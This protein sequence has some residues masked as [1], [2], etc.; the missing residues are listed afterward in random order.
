M[1]DPL[2]Q[3]FYS[4]SNC[5]HD[6]FSY[7]SFIDF[8]IIKIFDVGKKKYQVIDFWVKNTGPQ[9]LIERCERVKNLSELYKFNN[10]GYSVARFNELPEYY[11][12]DTNFVVKSDAFVCNKGSAKGILDINGKKYDINKF[13][14]SATIPV[15]EKNTNIQEQKDKNIVQIIQPINP[16]KEQKIALIISNC[17]ST[18][19]ASNFFNSNSAIMEHI[20]LNSGFTVIPCYNANIQQLNDCLNVYYHLSRTSKYSFTYIEGYA[21]AY[22]NNFYLIK[23][24][25]NE[26]KGISI[27]EILD[28]M[29]SVKNDKFEMCHT[30]ITE[31]YEGSKKNKDS[32]EI[33]NTYNILLNNHISDFS[34]LELFYFNNKFLNKILNHKYVRFAK[35]LENILISSQYCRQNINAIIYIEDDW[36]KKFLEK[37]SPIFEDVVFYKD[38]F[39]VSNINNFVATYKGKIQSDVVSWNNKK[40]GYDSLQSQ[41]ILNNRQL[42]DSLSNIN[43]YDYINDVKNRIDVHETEAGV[44]FGS[45]LT[46][47]SNQ[48]YDFYLS[49]FWDT[50][51][52]SHN[53][54]ELIKNKK[55]K[56]LEYS[57]Y[58]FLELFKNT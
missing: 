13:N 49:K 53:L 46:Q 34:N 40:E 17:E 52:N 8:L 28:S 12:V 2:C 16:D 35:K 33:N 36:Y 44:R 31:L 57:I 18:D 11:F 7:L 30:I 22:N 5:I 3:I 9:Q 48:F 39:F 4:F 32:E 24:K 55:A 41:F 6:H 38:T 14:I 45:H 25:R 23:P 37:Y 51:I 54:Y 20:M 10:T 50:V 43:L 21:F 27:I 42:I 1:F 26:D 47:E 58:G 15:I 19:D 29:Q 56:E